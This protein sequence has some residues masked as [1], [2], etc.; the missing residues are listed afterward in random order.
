MLLV[1]TAKG[2]HEHPQT[3][4][5]AE[6]LPTKLQMFWLCGSVLASWLWSLT[7]FI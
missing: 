3:H 7:G 6:L 5:L 1:Q 4:Q 2:M